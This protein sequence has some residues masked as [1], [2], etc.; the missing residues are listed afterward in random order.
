MSLADQ[1]KTSSNDEVEGKWFPYRQPNGDVVEL[2]IARAGG[3]NHAY[4]NAMRQLRR[5]FSKSGSL[6]VPIDQ[7]P[8]ALDGTLDAM[9]HFLLKGWRTKKPNGDVVEKIEHIDGKMVVFTFESAKDLLRGLPELRV[10]ITLKAADYA[11]FL[12]ID[13]GAV[14]GN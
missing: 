4:L 3:T 6:D 13:A 1:F 8:P 9:C 7:Y 5:Q 14:E 12:D 11:N 2:R 10:D